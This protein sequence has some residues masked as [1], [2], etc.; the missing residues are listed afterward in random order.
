[1]TPSAHQGVTRVQ[2]K[3]H[4]FCCI[5]CTDKGRQHLCSM[6]VEAKST[7][8]SWRGAMF[9]GAAAKGNRRR[10]PPCAGSHPSAQH[11][12]HHAIDSC[13]VH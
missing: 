1:M 5:T 10:A 11:T 9:T 12:H 8:R 2:S 7:R 4:S 6:R 3:E 13:T